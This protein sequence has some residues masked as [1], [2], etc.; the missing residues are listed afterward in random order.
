MFTLSQIQ[1]I[2]EEESEVEPSKILISAVE[3]D[4]H[5][6][7]VTN[8]IHLATSVSRISSVLIHK[9]KIQQDNALCHV[10]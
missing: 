8:L 7:L 2:Q 6:P 5:V 4:Q 10:A 3:Q 9:L 1:M